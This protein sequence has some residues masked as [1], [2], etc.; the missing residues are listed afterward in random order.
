MTK[1][2]KQSTK[3]SVHTRGVSR[4]KLYRTDIILDKHLVGLTCDF[5]Y[6]QMQLDDELEDAR[7]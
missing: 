7:I 6:K 3:P 4:S 1:F 2:T 5:L